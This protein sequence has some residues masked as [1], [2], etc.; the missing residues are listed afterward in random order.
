MPQPWQ[1]E[2]LKYY[3]ISGKGLDM[4][5][6]T[7]KIGGLGIDNDP[8]VKPDKV[9]DM[10]KTDLPAGI[11]DWIIS[12]HS[13]EHHND[14]IAVLCEWNRLLRQSGTLIIF[15]P[16]RNQIETTTLGDA[17]HKH[18]QIFDKASLEMFLYYCGFRVYEIA[19]IANA[20]FC[21]AKKVEAPKL[22]ENQR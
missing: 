5:C 2:A 13:L 20:I 6:G 3:T 9:M 1:R 17:E 14:T 7:E 8:K 12:C 22:P 4:G 15:T 18:K 21:V 10:A 16:D 11:H 19:V